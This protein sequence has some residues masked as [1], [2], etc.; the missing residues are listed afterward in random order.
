LEENEKEISIINMD[1]YYFNQL[2]NNLSKIENEYGAEV[3]YELAR[4]NA[5][6]ELSEIE[7]A[8]SVKS[9][10]SR[11][12]L[13]ASSFA[14]IDSLLGSD[15]ARIALH[16]M[17]GNW[18]SAPLSYSLFELM[19]RSLANID[20]VLE[21]DSSII[22]FIGIDSILAATE[23]GLYLRENGTDAIL[24][25]TASC[26]R[27]DDINCTSDY[28]LISVPAGRI[29][30]HMAVENSKSYSIN[31]IDHYEQIGAKTLTYY[32]TIYT[33]YWEVLDD[34]VNSM[35]K[36][37]KFPLK[38]LKKPHTPYKKWG[39]SKRIHRRR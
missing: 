25:G 37:L 17:I 16:N 5:A 24:L 4:Q 30:W 9:P 2:S 22:S 20:S 26:Y 3:S 13:P 18:H 12:E 6:F 23:A 28:Y 8:H 14:I 39:N 10:Y 35:M 33:E 31:L 36:T 27:N 21:S 15:S 1:R 34:N 38:D 19:N 11:L 29:L 32:R 7:D